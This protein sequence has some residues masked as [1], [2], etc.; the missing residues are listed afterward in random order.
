MYTKL[1]ESH[2]LA[3]SVG[4][5]TSNKN[6]AQDQLCSVYVLEPTTCVVTF[7]ASFNAPFDAP[8]NDRVPHLWSH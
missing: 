6:E 3:G 1:R 5:I 8:F 7:N 2:T 4:N